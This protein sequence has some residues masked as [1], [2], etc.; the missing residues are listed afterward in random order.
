MAKITH[1]DVGDVWVPQATFTVSGTPTDPTTI[2]VKV[3]EPD[4]TINTL[5]PVSGATGGGGIVRVSAGVFNT[6]VAIDASGYWAAQFT[7][8]G[9]AAASEDHEFIADPS[10]FSSNAG[11]SDRALVGLQE[12]K[13]WLQQQNIA[14]DNDLELVRVINDISE[15]AHEEAEREFKVVGT[16]PQTRTFAVEPR[17]SGRPWIVD[18]EYLGNL[19]PSSRL[20]AVGDMAVAP[21]AVEIIDHDW[22]TT[23]EVVSAGDVQAHPLT[24]KPWEPVTHLLFQTDVTSLQEGML[25][26]V[27]GNFGFPQVPGNVRQAV[28]DAIASVMDRDVEHYRQD[29]GASTVQGQGQ[30]GTVIMLAG[31]RQRMLSMPSSSLAVLWSYRNTWVG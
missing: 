6:L 20:V 4:G 18:G 24:R 7:G 10:L 21:T 26:E 31:G 15:R 23:L 25:V 13:D 27:T 3:R 19:H 28:L 29:L 12:T 30:G 2:T 5:G 1:G 16:N 11:L 17:P 9:A 8:T 14:T 22:T